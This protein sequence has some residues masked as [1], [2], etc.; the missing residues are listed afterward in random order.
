[1]AFLMVDSGPNIGHRYEL[2]PNSSL[3]LGRNESCHI[4][5]QLGPVSREHAEILH[6][7]DQYVIR[8][9]AS[10]N[11]TYVNENRLAP[12]EPHMLCNGDVVRVCDVTLSFHDDVPAGD[13]NLSGSASVATAIMDAVFVDDESSASKPDIM[14]KVDVSSRSGGVHMSA[15]PE[16]KLA[17]LI[18]IT[19][20][21]GKAVALDDVLPQVLKSLF[22]IFMQADRGFIVLKSES[23]DLVPRYTEFR[24]DSDDTIRISKTIVTQ[25]LETKS[26]V[27]SADAIT[28]DRFQMSQSIADFKIRSFMCVP[29]INS[30]DEAIGALQIDTLD[31]GK[32]FESEDLEVLASV[33]AQAGIAI[34][35][36]QLHESTLRQK[37]LERD[38]ELAHEVQHSFLPSNPPRLENYE[39]YDYYQPANHV[40]G[41]YYDYISLPD[42]RTAVIVADVV[43]HGVAA[44]L[45]MAKLSAEA[46]FN[47]AGRSTPAEAITRLNNSISGLQVDRFVTLVMTVLDPE[48][49]EVTIVNAGHMCPIFRRANG[50]IFEP[51]EE[52]AGLPVGVLD[53]MDY[54]Q[55]VVPL[56]PGESVT[57]YTDGLNEAMSPEQDQYGIDKIRDFVRKEG[58]IEAMS[59][60]LLDDIKAF[61]ADG[62]QD[63]DMCMVSFKRAV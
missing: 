19:K 18:E 55:I 38:L 14:S 54:E 3:K 4:R 9:L 21:L 5:I 37:G 6:N 58:D 16:A 29:L 2:N 10:R 24:R 23:G 59:E 20:S 63:D 61:V 52:E 41:D 40:G 25:V 7:E 42:G 35:N 49:H 27:L 26:A 8:D 12:Q 28:D 30:D 56:G 47:L 43:G 17:A 51:G 46:R 33:A 39:F 44:A 1:M 62:P 31:Q 53:D 36:A 50:E 34:S 60:H 22:K 32:R 45:L 48:K 11:G 15:S 13:T 57:M